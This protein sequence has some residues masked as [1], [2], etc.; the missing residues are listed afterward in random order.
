V[1]DA[2]LVDLGMGCEHVKHAVCVCVCVCVCVF[3]RE[4]VCMYAMVCL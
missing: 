3:E 1:V 4:C 2:V